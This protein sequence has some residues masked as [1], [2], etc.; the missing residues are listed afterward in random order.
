MQNIDFPYN[1][2]IINY[3]LV[4]PEKYVYSVFNMRGTLFIQTNF[5]SM[6]KTEKRQ[7]SFIACNAVCIVDR[8]RGNS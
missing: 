6:E 2:T 5:K 1:N 3:A 7:K 4:L 8:L